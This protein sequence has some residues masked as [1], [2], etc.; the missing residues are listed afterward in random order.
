MSSTTSKP[1]TEDATAWKQRGNEAFAAKRY[2]E[3][4]EH[5]SRALTH[6]DTQH[7]L[8]SN[9][10]AAYASKGAYAE[11]LADA[12]RCVALAPDWVKGY[13]R[14]GAA[15][16]GLG[17]LAEARA[18][19]EDGLQRDADNAG[20][21][22]GLAD[23]ER[24]EA[25]SGR[26]GAPSGLPAELLARLASDPRAQALLRDPQVMQALQRLRD[27]SGMMEA[28]QNPKL[29]ELFGLVASDM[30]MPEA[31]VETSEEAANGQ[32]SEHTTDAAA[33]PTTHTETG[34]DL[35]AHREAERL[36]SEGNAAYKRRDFDSALEHY[37]KAQELEP[38]NLVHLVNEAAVHFER[39]DYAKT[40]EL[41]QWAID[42]NRDEQ[43]GTDFKLVARA[44]ARMGN[45]HEHLN[46]LA[47][48]I[49]AYEKSLLEHHDDR[50]LLKLQACRRRK[51]QLDE[52]AY[53]DV[54]KSEQERE[55]GNT[56][57]KAG[58]FPQ[59]IEHYT[60]AHK[61]NP[62]DP[63]P[64]SNRAAAYIKL[65][66]LPSAIKDVDRALELDPKF[67]RAYARKGQAH[68]AMKEYHRALD[69]YEK[70]LEVDPNHAELRDGYMR[71]MMAIHNSNEADPER[72]ER[73][74]A[75]PEIQA[76][77][78]DPQMN[79]LLKQMESDPSAAQRAMQNPGVASK[80]RK[81]VA[82]GVV[83]MG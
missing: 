27:P 7:V 52:E 62:R 3:A 75:D 46:D 67:V 33:E 1:N 35:D 70:G 39:R 72:A 12:E 37:R 10:S 51:K 40:I 6:D 32:H 25:T 28:L 79:I 73:A 14:K 11:A 61:R 42:R 23:V 66:A 43:L 64:L 22:Q 83:R 49:D 19:F 56:A 38:N 21:R 59:A 76:I 2:D 48:A 30:D 5:F 34:V 36:K 17:R 65:G 60:E 78:M 57:F 58:D 47:A 20:L 8:Y 63:I 29:Q 54:D 50:V 9:R 15:L 24:A 13:S 82:A 55:A 26:G 4:I 45:A 74:L 68:F 81:L 80:I 69:A 31:D 71:V 53:I 41:C 44:Y 16:L 77:L 18:A